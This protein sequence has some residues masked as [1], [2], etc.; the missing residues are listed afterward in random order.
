MPTKKARK[1]YFSNLSMIPDERRY[2]VVDLTANRTIGIVGEEFI[3]LRARV[4]LHFICRGM[5]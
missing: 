4:G 5:V 1:Y 2:P 3:M